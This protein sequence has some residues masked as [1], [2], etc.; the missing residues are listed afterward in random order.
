MNI[1]VIDGQGGQLGGQIIKSL[2][3]NFSEADM[4]GATFNEADLTDSD[5]S[6]AENLEATR[7]DD[8]TIWPDLDKLPDDFDSTYVQDLSS[9][10][11]E[12]DMSSELDY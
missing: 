6:N 1:L 2:K 3:S 11:D 10:N 9:L 4:A 8:G 12:E 7:F 5:L